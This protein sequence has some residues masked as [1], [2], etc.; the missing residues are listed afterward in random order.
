MSIQ[1]VSTDFL[2][3]IRVETVIGITVLMIGATTCLGGQTAGKSSVLAAATEKTGVPRPTNRN[4]TRL[5]AACFRP[6]GIAPHGIPR[7]AGAVVPFGG[8][9]GVL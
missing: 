3:S 8:S 4:G 1:P 5:P 6:T 2:K 9:Q 7:L